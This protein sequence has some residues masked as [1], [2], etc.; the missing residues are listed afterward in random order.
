MQIR[1]PRPESPQRKTADFQV[2]CSLRCRRSRTRVRVSH[3][4]C[5]LDCCLIRRTDVW[6]CRRHRKRK[7][8][9]FQPPKMPLQGMCVCMQ[10]EVNTKT[11]PLMLV[12][13]K[14]LV[15]IAARI[16]S[17]VE[18][19]NSCRWLVAG[20][21]RIIVILHTLLLEHDRDVRKVDSVLVPPVQALGARR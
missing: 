18:T 1:A 8:A 21:V 17:T 15:C 16:Y 11:L 2:Y 10:L 3:A 20:N 5:C 12:T 7:N 9:G 14:M 13:L 19:N 6:P 4:M